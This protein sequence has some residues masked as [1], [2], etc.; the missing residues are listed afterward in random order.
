MAG[1]AVTVGVTVEVASIR[2][3]TITGKLDPLRELRQQLE[4]LAEMTAT[5]GYHTA[6]L[7]PDS[8]GL[9]VPTLAAVQTF[10]NKRTPKR[11]FM[12]RA[13]KAVEKTMTP[14]AAEAIEG[15]VMKGEATPV[16]V[17]KLGA[18]MARTILAELESAGSWAKANAAATL[19][20]KG[21]LP[22]LDDGH[23]TLRKGLSYEVQRR[24][25]T[26]VEGKPSA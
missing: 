7:V 6:D 16:A 18:E 19:R 22:P 24:D 21:P 14:I 26:I 11:P 4:Q 15:V 13:A 17:Q 12:Q 2:G 9:T 25:T 3:G 8:G 23:G 20:E 1:K 10:G 5:A